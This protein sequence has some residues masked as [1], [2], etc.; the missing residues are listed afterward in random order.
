MKKL[1]ILF[2]FT[3]VGVACHAQIAKD[4][5]IGGHLDLIKTDNDNFFD[6]AQIGTEVN[7]FLT[8]RFTAT[9]GLEVWTNDDAS[10][11]VGGRWYFM[12]D[13]FARIRG[14][15]GANDLSIGA[16]WAKPFNANG[17]WRFEAIG[18]FYFRGDIA[19]RAGIAY[20]IRKNPN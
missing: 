19:I 3:F 10:L 13:A 15:V 17:N 1:T 5:L 8:R 20:L 14:L 18:D 12:D 4:I 16:G 9:G 7:Y 2:L 6:K 11:V